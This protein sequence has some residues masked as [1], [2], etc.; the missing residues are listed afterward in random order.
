MPPDSENYSERIEGQYIS[1]YYF[2]S[3]YDPVKHFEYNIVF[4][5]DGTTVNE[6]KT[7]DKQKEA[8]AKVLEYHFSF[9]QVL[10][11]EY[12]DYIKFYAP[13]IINNKM[14]DYDLVERNYLE[15]T[16]SELLSM[17]QILPI[18]SRLIGLVAEEGDMEKDYSEMTYE[19][20]LQFY[21]DYNNLPQYLDATR[22]NQ[23]SYECAVYCR[24]ERPIKLFK[25]AGTGN[26]IPKQATDDEG[27]P[28]Y[29]DQG[30]PVYVTVNGFDFR[31]NL[32]L[33]NS[34]FQFKLP[35]EEGWYRYNKLNKKWEYLCEIVP[36]AYNPGV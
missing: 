30:N 13:T 28:I 4:D 24:I 10:P 18:R 11:K 8:L 20:L 29:D 16:E 6:E 17:N 25:E 2:Y 36:T 35:R 32:S 9:E 31:K 33:V 12:V 22:I 7:L 14:S 3:D 15:V 1:S 5:E 26:W 27:N 23:H 21:S 34:I 19:E